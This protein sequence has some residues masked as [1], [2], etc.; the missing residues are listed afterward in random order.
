MRE[1][2]L[3]DEF[4]AAVLKAG[5]YSG[6]EPAYLDRALIYVHVLSRAVLP[7]YFSDGN[8]FGCVDERCTTW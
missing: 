5:T 2:D 4:R 3:T 6:I 1:E 8:W 7:R